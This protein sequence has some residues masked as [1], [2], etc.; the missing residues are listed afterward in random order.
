MASCSVAAS[1]NRVVSAAT[2]L[3]SVLMSS[4]ER[5]S[6][7]LCAS[8]VYGPEVS[9]RHRNVHRARGAP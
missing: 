4:A 9:V 8:A 6:F 7:S 5:R 1:S 2:S 3:R